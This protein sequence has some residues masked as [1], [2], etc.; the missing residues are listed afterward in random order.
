MMYLKTK[1]NCV[2]ELTSSEVACLSELQS[3]PFQIK[4]G[5][6]IAH[7]G[8]IARRAF[9]LQ[10]G[11]ASCYK[12]SRDGDRQIISFPLPGDFMGLGSI[13]LRS[14]NYSFAALSDVVV[15]SLSV[16][17][18]MKLFEKFPRVAAAILL[19]ASRDEAM[20]IE[21][22]VNVG[23][24]SAIERVAHCLLEL[25]QRL[26]LVGL[27]SESQF[28]CPLTQYDLA[29]SLGLS[30]IHVNRVLRYLREE[31]MLTIKSHTVNVHNL[32]GLIKL[33]GF[34]SAYL[35]Q[36]VPEEVATPRAYCRA[37]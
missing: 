4:R 11:W 35:D 14:S 33:A 29:D 25:R 26:R 34:D 23:R 21:H 3:Q 1:L 5:T 30:P 27:A 2:V 37:S 31:G 16:P 36:I 24:R 7:E 17:C 19:S 9:I 15:S 8:Q 12:Y 13:L 22:L 32:A 6:E 28:E 18:V 20:V 10:S